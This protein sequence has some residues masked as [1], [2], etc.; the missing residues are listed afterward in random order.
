MSKVKI[1]GLKP[2]RR[3]GMHFNNNS[4]QLAW[5]DSQAELTAA[6][7]YVDNLVVIACLNTIQLWTVTQS[8]QNVP[9][10]QNSTD[11]DWQKFGQHFLFDGGNNDIKLFTKKG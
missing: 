5:A 1:T 2:R 10:C 6:L 8:F 11:I 9:I 4:L 7:Q 3:L